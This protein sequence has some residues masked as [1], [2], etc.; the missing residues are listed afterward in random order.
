MSHSNTKF[1]NN[2]FSDLFFDVKN[3]KE[4]PLRFYTDGSVGKSSA[5]WGF[6]V[7]EKDTQSVINKEKEIKIYHGSAPKFINSSTLAET[8]AIIK[9]LDYVEQ[10]NIS[11]REVIIYTDCKTLTHVVQK[12]GINR[13][14]H[15]LFGKMFLQLF[16]KIESLQERKVRVKIRYTKAHHCSLEETTVFNRM[17]DYT[18]RKTMRDTE[19]KRSKYSWK[20]KLTEQI[21]SFFL[22]E[23]ESMFWVDNGKWSQ[24]HILEL[25]GK[26]ARTLRT[27][28]TQDITGNIQQRAAINKEKKKTKELLEKVA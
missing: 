4:E 6:L 17:V 24:L 10:K 5:S 12:S 15:S 8:L 28:V 22:G 13:K 3:H 7:K 16:N 1:E 25:N 18:V 20:K 2:V 19:E 11:H 23:K 27:K 9:V 26:S 14:R 21:S